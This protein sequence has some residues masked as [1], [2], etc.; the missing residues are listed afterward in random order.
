MTHVFL[1]WRSAAWPQTQ[2]SRGPCPKEAQAPTKPVMYSCVCLCVPVTIMY[3]SLAP[4]SVQLFNWIVH[5]YC[6]LYRY[7]TRWS[8][9]SV[10]PIYKSGLKWS[11]RRMPVGDPAL[12]DNVCYSVKPLYLKH[13]RTESLTNRC[14]NCTRVG[15]P[16]YIQVVWLL[17]HCPGNRPKSFIHL[18]L[19]YLLFI[20]LR[21]TDNE[22]CSAPPTTI[23]SVSKSPWSEL[24]GK[25]MWAS[26]G[27]MLQFQSRWY[28]DC[29]YSRQHRCANKMLSTCVW[30]RTKWNKNSMT[31]PLQ[32][33]CFKIR[34]T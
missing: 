13:W 19:Y 22:S 10:K 28:V 27:S 24:C 15:G 17:S 6:V 12:K 20:K 1:C 8:I 14:S 23:Y 3:Q 32:F 33:I 4:V 7:L 5:L 30:T 9:D 2:T 11:K 29:V 18:Y 26:A 31:G 25:L 16:F 34:Q 21:H